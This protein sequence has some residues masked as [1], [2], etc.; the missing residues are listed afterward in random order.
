MRIKY[1]AFIILAFLSQRVALASVGG[2]FAGTSFP[3]G[4][5]GTVYTNQTSSMMRL[6]LSFTN[7]GVCSTSISWTDATGDLKSIKIDPN[8]SPVFST[9]LPPQGVL[10]WASSAGS[11]FVG[12]A[13]DLEQSPSQSVGPP[14]QLQSTPC[15]STGILYQN[16][17]DAIITV[18]LA[19]SNSASCGLTVSWTDS[20]GHT[21]T[22]AVALGGS[23]GVST[24]IPAGGTIKWT[25]EGTSG[26]VAAQWQLE[27]RVLESMNP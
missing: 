3:C 22:I 25:A 6:E 17:T 10:S 15:G 14:T 5:I 7:E 2:V 13:W 16:L 12:F 9:S 4:S 21:Y 20:T 26:V 23:L 27:R 8:D 24:T 19:V 18:N 11:G 1:L